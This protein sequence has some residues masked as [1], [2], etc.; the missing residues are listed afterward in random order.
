M[1]QLPHASVCISILFGDVVLCKVVDKDGSQRLVLALVG[2]GI[3]V[4]KEPSATGVVHACILK[5]LVGFRRLPPLESHIKNEVQ[6]PARRRGW[7][8][9]RENHTALRGHSAESPRDA[10]RKSGNIGLDRPTETSHFA[11]ETVILAKKV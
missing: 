3:G 5:V 10:K 9:A 1:N 2:R 4:Q 11:V 6:D 8:P 7:L